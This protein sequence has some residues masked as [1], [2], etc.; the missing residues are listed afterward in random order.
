MTGE[1]ELPL[2]A[3]EE[4]IEKLLADMDEECNKR[5]ESG[6]AFN[7]PTSTGHGIHTNSESTAQ[8]IERAQRVGRRYGRH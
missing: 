5:V 4:D 1:H 3:S 2:G 8:K 6:K 7:E